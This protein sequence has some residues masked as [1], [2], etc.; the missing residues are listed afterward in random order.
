MRVLTNRVAAALSVA[1]IGSAAVNL[2]VLQDAP[3]RRG[4]A[5][6]HASPNAAFPEPPKGSPAS[7]VVLNAAASQTNEADIVRGVQRELNAR[8]YEAGQPDGAPGLVTRA[9]VMAYEHDYSLALTATPSE[10]L[11]S[12][13]VL[14][15]SGP[16]APQRAG[17]KPTAEAESVIRL[18]KQHLAALGYQPGRVDGV[19]GPEAQRAIREF[20]SDQKLGETGRISGPMMSR[21]LRLQGGAAAKDQMAKAAT[22]KTAAAKSPPAKHPR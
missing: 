1:L 12:R 3:A 8:N 6:A 21:L 7:P 11:L 20:E 22:A 16:Q 9:A 14:G 10:E 13:I 19:L 5:A 2:T 15:S 4:A 18:V 17:A